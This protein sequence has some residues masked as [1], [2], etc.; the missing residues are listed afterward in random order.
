M[1]FALCA[2]FPLLLSTVP[3]S[4]CHSVFSI[5]FAL[6]LGLVHPFVDDLHTLL[7]LASATP[8]ALARGV[9]LKCALVL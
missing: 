5:A 7:W 1:L 9:P 8:T 3:T 4:F 2:R 6:D